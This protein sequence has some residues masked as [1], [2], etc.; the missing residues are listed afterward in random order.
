MVAARIVSLIPSATEIVAALDCTD[1]LVGRSHECDVPTAVATLPIC[2]EPRIDVNGT[3]RQ[4]DD[5]VKAALQDALSV[6]RVHTDVLQQLQ[7]SVILTQAQCDVCAV[8]LSDVQESVCELT[9]CDPAVVSLTPMQLS[10][11]WDDIRRVAQALDVPAKGDA[12]VADLQR[13]LKELRTLTAAQPQRPC[14][15]CIEWIEPLMVAGN[16]IPELVEIAG[17]ESLLAV[18]GE[19]S[20]WLEWDALAAADPDRIVVVPCGFGLDR[21]AGEM[22]TLESHP[23]WSQLRAVQNGHVYLIDG[24]H[25]FNRPG[26]RLVESAEILTEILHPTAARFG[27]EGTGWRR[28]A[29]QG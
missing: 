3:S 16:W 22:S 9:G 23:A 21:T 14:V 8:N 12:V 25:Y 26:P 20:P 11:V 28:W 29:G 19:H 17:G 7:P 1:R 2:S 5:R 18:A 13:R 15:A 24:H 10:D 4:I 6:Y 27:H